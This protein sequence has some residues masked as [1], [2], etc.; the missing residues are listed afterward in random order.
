M[1]SLLAYNRHSSKGKTVLRGLAVGIVLFLIPLKEY[2]KDMLKKW[3]K[4]CGRLCNWKNSENVQNT[5]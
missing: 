4:Q 2:C 5:V 3:P 1:I